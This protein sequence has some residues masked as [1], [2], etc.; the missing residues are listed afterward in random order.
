LVFLLMKQ[1]L[2]KKI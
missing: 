2:L 1:L